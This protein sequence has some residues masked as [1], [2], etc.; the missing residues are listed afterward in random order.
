MRRLKQIM[1][2]LAVFALLIFAQ[3]GFLTTGVLNQKA[4]DPAVAARATDCIPLPAPAAYGLIQTGDQSHPDKVIYCFSGQP[5]D[6]ILSFQVYDIDS[7]READIFL[8]GV[9]VF[10]VPVT[11]DNLWSGNFSV[12]LQDALVKDVGTNEVVFDNTKNPPNSWWWGVRQVSVGSCLPLP[13]VAAYGK[14]QGGDQSHADKVAYCFPGRIGDMYLSYQ[15]YDIDSMNEVEI[16]VNGIKV[17]DVP[18]TAKNEW[19]G[20]LGV[21]L[22]DALV[23]NVGVNIV[24]FDNTNNPPGANSWGVRQ[25]SIQSCFRLTATAA[26]GKI[27]RGDQF[28]TDKVVYG[29]WGQPGDLYLLYQAYDI[30]SINEVDVFL[31][32]VKV[33]DVPSTGNNKWSGYLG[34]LLPDALIKDS[35]INIVIF[36]NTQNP[37]RTDWWG[38]RQVSVEKYFTLPSA[39]TYGRILG[40]DQNHTDKVVYFFGGQTGTPHLSFQ[41]YDI[42]YDYELDIFLNSVKIQDVPITFDNE[43]S[44]TRTIVLPDTLVNDTATNVLIFDNT[45][46]PPQTWFWGVRGVSINATLSQQRS[47]ETTATTHVALP[48]E[49]VLQQ[50]YPNPFNPTTQIRYELPKAG[51][52]ALSIFNSLG[53]EVRRLVDRAQ[54]A[55]Y[56]LVTWNGRDQNGKPVPSGV[57]HY[58]LQV[59]DFVS[60]KKMIMAK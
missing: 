59:G 32:G 27:Q 23:N 10:D 53:Q 34:V 26:F 15:A 7:D 58:R 50:N 35:G 60:T 17:Q 14:I 3:D 39:A 38:V 49:F 51:H 47:I 13:S 21:Y 52:V 28:H 31:N 6:V 43:W 42:D 30:D 4:D 24:I 12:L 1:I 56:H 18:L 54:P 20:N 2:M 5:G 9:K 45:R 22:P 25:V 44:T 16:F 40:G 48:A 19:S 55:G 8:N 46:N 36:D 57:Y 37:P 11:G 33:L 29:F 41:V